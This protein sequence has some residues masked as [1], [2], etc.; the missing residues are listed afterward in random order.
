MEGQNPSYVTVRIHYIVFGGVIGILICVVCLVF[1]L[2]WSQIAFWCLVCG[3]SV[4]SGPVY[5]SAM[6]W[7]DRYTEM[8]GI[9]VGVVD[10]GI[11]AGSFVALYFGDYLIHYYGPVY[12]FIMGASGVEYSW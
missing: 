4:L 3:I 5:A 8:E 7:A 11:G 2:A 1:F 10:I 6:A 12:V 9:M